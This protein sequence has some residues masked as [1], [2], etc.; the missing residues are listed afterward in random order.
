MNIF[1]LVLSRYANL[2]HDFSKFSF[3]DVIT[4]LLYT[5]IVCVFQAKLE[6]LLER[7]LS[8]FVVKNVRTQGNAKTSLHILKLYV[9]SF[10]VKLFKV[11]S[12]VVSTMLKK[13]NDSTTIKTDNLTLEQSFNLISDVYLNHSGF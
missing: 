6:C 12:F 4:S 1:Y 5:P 3:C 8:I 11:H 2:S 9:L 13:N 10:N 7:Q